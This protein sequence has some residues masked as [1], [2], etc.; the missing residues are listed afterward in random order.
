[1]GP[2]QEAGQAG[3]PQVPGQQG[4]PPRPALPHPAPPAGRAPARAGL[5]RGGRGAEG[6]GHATTNAVVSSSILILI[7]NYLVTAL[8]FG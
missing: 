2:D 6:V 1:M 7:S 5:T 8:F 3:V 4:A